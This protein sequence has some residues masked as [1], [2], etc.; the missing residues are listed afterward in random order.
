IITKAVCTGLVSLVAILGNIL[1]ISAVFH[2]K[3]MRTVTNYLIV[4]LAVAELLYILVAMPPF[5]VEIFSLYNWCMS[6]Y[7]RG[8]YFCKIVN[9]GQYLLVPVSVLT[10]ACIAADRFFAIVVPL[11][12][13]LTKRVFYWLV[14]GIWVVSAGLAAPVLYAYRVVEW[15]GHLMCS[16]EWGE[17][18]IAQH[19]SRIYTSMLFVVAYC[20]PFAVMAT[21]YT[22]ICRKLWLRKVPGSQSAKK[23]SKAVE[24]R[25]KV[26][27]MLI[28]VFV[29]FVACWLPVQVLALM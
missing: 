17:G 24:S 23:S 20:V 8:V 9:F 7:T 3:R 16:E 14:P 26:V 19:A 4:N 28:T 13:V 6:T 29:V 18:G 22:V 27:K 5:F 12:R 11:K 10:L 25:K 15:G 21:M 1:V 2:V